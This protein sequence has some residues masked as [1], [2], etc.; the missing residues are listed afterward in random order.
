VLAIEAPRIA[1]LDEEERGRPIDQHLPGVRRSP[2]T[3]AILDL[4]PKTREEGYLIVE[5]RR[6]VLAPASLRKS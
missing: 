5:P 1:T 6:L 4:E 3:G 2:Y